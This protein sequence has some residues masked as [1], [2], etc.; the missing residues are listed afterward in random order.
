[1]ISD[2][3]LNGFLHSDLDRIFDYIITNDIEKFPFNRKLF[4]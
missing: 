3:L 1:M 2:F 4:F